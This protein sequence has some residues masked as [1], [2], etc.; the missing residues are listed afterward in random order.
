[1]FN[2]D[3]LTWCKEPHFKKQHMEPAPP[4]TV[5]NKKKEYEVKKV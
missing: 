1:M 5:V 2:E 4:L 3:L